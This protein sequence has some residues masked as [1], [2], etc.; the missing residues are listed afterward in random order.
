MINTFIRCLRSEL[1]HWRAST[2]ALHHP[3]LPP[4]SSAPPSL[5][6]P[7]HWQHAPHNGWHASPTPDGQTRSGMPHNGSPAASHPTEEGRY[8]D[9]PPGGWGGGDAGPPGSLFPPHSS[10]PNH[11]AFPSYLP[12]IISHKVVL[13]SFRISQLP[14]TSV[15]L[16]F[17]ITDVKSKLTD[18]CGN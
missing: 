7:A 16:S 15:N 11:R 18:F 1:L 8:E 9:V 17:T 10:V 13:K 6:A 2:L 12:R 4:S 14:H 3:L 5:P